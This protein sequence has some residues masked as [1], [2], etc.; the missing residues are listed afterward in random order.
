MIALLVNDRAGTSCQE[1]TALKGNEINSV[2]LVAALALA[3]YWSRD[4]RNM[5]RMKI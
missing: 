4:I 1:A 3:A 2:I 5:A